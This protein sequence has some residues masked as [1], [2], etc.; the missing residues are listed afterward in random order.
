MEKHLIQWNSNAEAFDLII[1]L[2]STSLHLR[3]IDKNL[4]STNFSCIVVYV[5]IS[6]SR[7][8]ELRSPYE[9]SEVKMAEIDVFFL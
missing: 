5:Q 3:D 8:S 1:L 4:R 9:K 2:F 7:T 6:G